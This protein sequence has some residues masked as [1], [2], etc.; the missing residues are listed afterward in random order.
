MAASIQVGSA[1]ITMGVD[2]RQ[3]EQ[4]LARATRSTAALAGSVRGIQSTLDRF[5]SSVA[6]SLIATA[7][8]AAGVTAIRAAVFGSARDFLQFERGLI[9]VSKTA[10]LSSDEM[11][12]LGELF[13]EATTQTSILGQALPATT[14]QLTDIATV[15][16]QANVQGVENISRLTQVIAALGETTDLV[17]EQA[18]NSFTLLIQTTDATFA[19]A[20]RLGSAITALGNSFRGGEAGLLSYARRLAASTQNANLAATDILALSAVIQ[21]LGLQSETSATA[22][23]RTFTSLINAASEATEGDLAKLNVIFQDLRDDARGLA[24]IRIDAEQLVPRI[25]G[26]DIDALLTLLEALDSTDA[27]GRISILREL[28]GGEVPPARLTEVL[29]SLTASIGELRRAL[30]VSSEA[31]AE[32]SALVEEFE[33][34]LS[35]LDKQY[36]VVGNRIRDF[37]RDLGETVARGF[38]PVAQSFDTIAIAAAGLAASL[39]SAFAGR[40]ISAVRAELLAQRRLAQVQVDA[41]RTRLENHQE[42]LRQDQRIIASNDGVESARRANLRRGLRTRERSAAQQRA[43]IAQNEGAQKRLNRLLSRQRQL[44]GDGALSISAAAKESTRAS[45]QAALAETQRLIALEQPRAR[46]EQTARRR[47]NRDL[48]AIRDRERRSA[49]SAAASARN[50]TLRFNAASRLEQR[51]L[52]VASSTEELARRQAQLARAGRI[53]TSVMRGLSS[54][55]RFFGGG[56]GVTI[57]LIT[58]GTLAWSRWNRQLRQTQE[59]SARTVEAVRALREEVEIQGS[60]LTDQGRRYLALEQE[61]EGIRERLAPLKEDLAEFTE[62]L[63]SVPDGL[64]ALERLGEEGV[65]NAALPRQAQQEFFALLEAEREVARELERISE[66]SAASEFSAGFVQTEEAAAR[67]NRQLVLVNEGFADLPERVNAYRDALEDASG[68]VLDDLRFDLSIVGDDLLQQD[69]ERAYRS[70]IEP[71]ERA[72]RDEER[73][74]RDLQDR[75]FALERLQRQAVADADSLRQGTTAQERAQNLAEGLQRRIESTRQELELSRALVVELEAVDLEEQRAAA[76]S[77]AR[78]RRQ[79]EVE[80]NLNYAPQAPA[81]DD[82]AGRIRAAELVSQL[83]QRTELR[84]RELSNARLVE[85]ADS[86][87]AAGLQARFEIET[88]VQRA[89]IELDAQREI[90]QLRLEEALKREQR[91]RAEI[92][93]AAAGSQR[94]LELSNQLPGL[95]DQIQSLR[96]VKAELASY[97][98]EMGQ[99]AAAAQALADQNQRLAE[100]AVLGPLRELALEAG[101]FSDKLE[102]VTTGSLLSLEDQLVRTFETGKFSVRDLANEIFSTLIRALIRTII[103]ANLA[104]A[105]LGAFPF[106]APASTGA[107]TPFFHSGGVAGR[108]APARAGG[109]L[110]DSDEIFAIL[111]KGELVV[112]KS[113]SRRLRGG[114]W[115]AYRQLRGWVSGLPKFHEGGIVGGAGRAGSGTTIR[116]V[117]ESSTQLEAADGGEYFDAGGYVRSVILRDARRNGELTQALRR[118]VR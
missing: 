83:R 19:D 111:Q 13:R 23:Q 64:A 118:A 107:P 85:E 37:S 8:Y 18:A 52:S 70:I 56:L 44:Q 74:A 26:G 27:A 114:D 10:G 89:Q 14:K 11:Q 2:A 32:N 98:A 90:N 87:T 58:A 77:I 106:L 71:A 99:A 42:A 117:N 82:S 34:S 93:S 31:F 21:Q 12:R 45:R 55:Y 97:S 28:F 24:G 40:R 3:F 62:A 91:L 67:A 63:A 94:R 103:T 17:G 6:N 5:R 95:R 75:V 112:P 38:L 49:A 115:E 48:A 76:I 53:T 43:I 108:S 84:Q 102:G 81:A 110:V 104:Q 100:G 36:A 65:A 116:L 72:I 30:N 109:R 51:Q 1:H 86:R 79:L 80:R 54:V 88:A 29:G 41:A 59:S 15:L 60:A 92:A 46:A 7:A 9:N 101:Q 57:G 25:A 39:G 68:D 50:E 35:G 66:I 4:G 78:S 113:L 105:I 96:Q 20:E 22:I 61:L 47:L 33:E 69:A 16:G 73:K